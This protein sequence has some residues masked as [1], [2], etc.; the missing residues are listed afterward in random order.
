MKSGLGISDIYDTYVE[1]CLKLSEWRLQT[2]AFFSTIT[3]TTLA[4]YPIIHQEFTTLGV[5]KF[6]LLTSLILIFILIICIIWFITIQ[7]YRKLSSNKF[8][9]LIDIEATLEQAPFS[10]ENELNRKTNTLAMTFLESLLPI[11]SF[12]F[13]VSFAVV[14]I[15]F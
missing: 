11:V 13:H 7:H 1:S 6:N 2:N 4:A 5:T 9:V 10:S 3:I 8:Q 15:F 14:M 12:C